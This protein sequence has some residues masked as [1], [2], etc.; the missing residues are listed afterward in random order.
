MRRIEP[1]TDE[2]R[3]LRQRVLRA[4]RY[5]LIR[6][7]DK[8]HTRPDGSVEVLE[9]GVVAIL[10]ALGLEVYA[11]GPRKKKGRYSS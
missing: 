6:R 11:S 10:E 4:A 7:H 3:R 2:Q 5:G 1:L 8:V 9:Y